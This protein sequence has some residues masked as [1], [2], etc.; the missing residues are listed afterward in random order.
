MDRSVDACTEKLVESILA[1]RA[2]CRFVKAQEALER[3]PGLKE[4][5]NRYRTDIFKLYEDGGE[6][7]I[8]TA[9]ELEKKF[10]SMQKIPEVNAYLDAETEICRMV[11]N[12][13]QR[14]I[15]ETGVEEP[16]A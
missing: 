6:D 3:Y 11:R 12:I 16:E 10:Q 7:I 15:S 9:E 4:K 1:S 13:Y 5:I 2:Y 8:N 14:L